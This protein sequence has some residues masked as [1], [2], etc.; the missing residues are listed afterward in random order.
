MQS[1]STSKYSSNRCVLEAFEK[2]MNVY[3][4]TIRNVLV[5]RGQT[6]PECLRIQFSLEDLGDLR[7]EGGAPTTKPRP[8]QAIPP[9]ADPVSVLYHH[10]DVRNICNHTYSSVSF[11]LLLGTSVSLSLS[12]GVKGRG[13]RRSSPAKMLQLEPIQPPFGFG[14]P[15]LVHSSLGSVCVLRRHPPAA[16]R[17]RSALSC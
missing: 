17:A 4:T 14:S 10:P 5:H 11:A 12:A 15:A 7:V 3:T 6:D 8:L 16:A 9:R 13:D 1:D 2:R